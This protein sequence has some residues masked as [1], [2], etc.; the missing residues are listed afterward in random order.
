MTEAVDHH[1]ATMTHVQPR[2]PGAVQALEE[3]QRHEQRGAVGVDLTVE[4]FEQRLRE[5]VM[6][7]LA[8]E[9]FEGGILAMADAMNDAA[10]EQRVAEITRQF[11]VADPAQWS[12]YETMHSRAMLA[13]A[14]S[15]VERAFERHG[16]TLKEYPAVGTLT[17]GQV[18]ATTQRAPGT[19]APLVLVDNG[20]PRFGIALAQLTVQGSLEAAHGVAFTGPTVQL[21]SDLV[22]TH[23]VVGTCLYTYPRQIDPQIHASVS[24]LYDAL[25]IFVIAHEY[26]HIALG[27]IDEFEGASRHEI[28]YRADAYGLITALETTHEHGAPGAGAYGA[29]LYLA[30]LDLIARARAVYAGDPPPPETNSV[31]PT[32][33]ERANHLLDMVEGSSAVM[34]H[35]GDQIRNAAK[36][37]LLILNVWRRVEPAFAACREAL[38]QCDSSHDHQTLPEVVTH[39][40]VSILW[41]E[42]QRRH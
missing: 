8:G 5:D 13:D 32:P 1:E 42:V 14:C 36:C 11:T 37:Y 10:V 39:T 31:Y 19:G 28:E 15:R 9:A 23:V 22:V 17:T 2:P 33:F 4:E 35:F 25:T 30:G 20:F 18:G 29:F 27:D 3:L 38:R 6:T 24:A 40:A 34:T 16:W 21:L 26:A 41:Q 12:R 7:Q